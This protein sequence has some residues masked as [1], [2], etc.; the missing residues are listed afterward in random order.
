MTKNKAMKNMKVYEIHTKSENGDAIVVFFPVWTKH[1]LL[2]SPEVRDGD[3]RIHFVD[4]EGRV[5]G[6]R[7]TEQDKE[8]VT[9]SVYREMYEL[10]DT[11][12]INNAVQK[13]NRLHKLYVLMQKPRKCGAF[14]ILTNTSC[15]LRL[16]RYAY[17]LQRTYKKP[18]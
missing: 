18:Q 7:Y 14:I 16:V 13:N 10:S 4:C 1:G 12:A 15:S 6:F 9:L 2:I 11:E 17:T 3:G 8:R 5:S